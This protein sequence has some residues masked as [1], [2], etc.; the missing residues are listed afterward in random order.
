M[1]KKENI[2]AVHNKE[3]AHDDHDHDHGS[4]ADNSG[5]IWRT[6]WA[7]LLAL[8]LLFLE[9]G[10]QFGTNTHLPLVA[11]LAINIVAY[12][13]AGH[14][15]LR[16]AFRKML[17]FD[18]F[19]EFFLMS[20]ATLGAFAIGAYSEGVAVMVFYSIGEWVQDTA[21][22]RAKGSIKALL[23]IRPDTVTVIRN[24]KPQSVSPS[25]VEIGE[26]IQVR[27][28]EKVALDGELISDT[29][30][31]NSA[32]LTGESAPDN[33]EKGE[34]IYAGMINLDTL[35]DIKTTSEFTDSKLSRILSLV[36]DATARKS[37]TQLFISRFAAVYTPIVFA[38]AML[39]VGLPY[40]FV[41]DYDF[42]NWLYR[43]LVFLVI[44]S[45][46]RRHFSCVF[47]NCLRHRM[48]R[49]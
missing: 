21:V 46:C 13:L 16:L 23:D 1:K 14:N 15:V 47:Y 11:R 41:A 27:H 24:G 26:T 10:L 4:A 45:P 29:A 17:R 33:K 32:A 9:L 36:Q 7:L 30:V 40:F 6:H 42:Q 37:Q 34:S 3:H 43:G 39:V 44:S 12:L 2:Q 25:T 5:G 8:V 22:S 49:F 35:I 31:L 19:N 38:L 20:V 48:G 28:G 18:F